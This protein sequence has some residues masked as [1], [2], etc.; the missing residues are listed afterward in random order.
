[1]Q[2]IAA[3]VIVL[4]VEAASFNRKA[5]SVFFMGHPQTMSTHNRGR[6]NAIA[7]IVRRRGVLIAV[8]TR[9]FSQFVFLV[10]YGSQRDAR[11]RVQKTV[12]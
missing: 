3:L 5:F 9:R 1:M 6:I 11:W 10:A 2:F 7:A 12:D 4:N 8:V